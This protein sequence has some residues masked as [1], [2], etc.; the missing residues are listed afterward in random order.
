[1]QQ[2][3]PEPTIK[4]ITVKLKHNGIL[5]NKEPVEIQIH[6]PIADYTRD[7]MASLKKCFEG[8]DAV[9]ELVEKGYVVD[10]PSTGEDM[11]KKL[12]VIGAPLSLNNG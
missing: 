3:L 9:R 7:E 12:V 11:V 8:A 1:M 6:V 10:Q 2:T 4:K 5:S